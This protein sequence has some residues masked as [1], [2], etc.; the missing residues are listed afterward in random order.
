[1]AEKQS[2]RPASTSSSNGQSSS[3]G[4]RASADSETN[5]RAAIILEVLAG[6]RT[7]SDAAESLKISVNYYYVLERKAVQGLVA[8]CRPAPKGPPGP[9]VKTQLE[10]LKRELEQCRHE[11]QRQSA[12]VRATERAIGIRASSTTK[13]ATRKGGKLPKGKR[14]RK[15]AVRA[16]QA[17]ATLRENS[18]LEL[19]REKLETAVTGKAD[20]KTTSVNHEESSDGKMRQEAVGRSSG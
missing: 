9:T 11:C 19:S 14:R 6:V 10:R 2:S 15:P 13:T 7:P 18:A 5:R 17:A 8:A 16:L 12:L 1:M 3:A 20:R 4:S